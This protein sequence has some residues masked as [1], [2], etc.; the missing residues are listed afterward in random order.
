ME[1]KKSFIII[2]GASQGI[3][4]CLAINLSNY[5]NIVLHGRNLERLRET[6]SLCSI[7]NKQIIFSCDLV[8]T[9]KIESRLSEFI[10]ANNIEIIHYVHCAGFMKMLPLKMVTLEM[11]NTTFTTN[12]L[13]AIFFAKVLTQRKINGGSLKSIVFVSSNISNF[14]A[15]AFSVYAASKG[16]LDS[17]MRCLAVELSP[18]IRINSVLPGA[19]KT[20]MTEN[21]YENKETL[22]KIAITYPLGLGKPEDIFEIVHFLLSEKARWITGQQLTV[23]G[24]RTINISG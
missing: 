8:E 3:G 23:D 14:G 13:S 12:I 2:T 18:R 11:V 10:V 16:A 6:K 5:Y 24:G 17:L 20:P 21:I 7:E 22:E 15:K 19:I 1:N 9:D 4:R